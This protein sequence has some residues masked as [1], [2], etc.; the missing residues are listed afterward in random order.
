MQLRTIIFGNR[1]G[2]L[3]RFFIPVTAQNRKIDIEPGQHPM[4][5]LIHCPITQQAY[6]PTPDWNRGGEIIAP[7]PVPIDH[8][9]VM[10]DHFTGQRQ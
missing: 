4:H 2:H 5:I 1:G 3:S 8:P 10:R 7:P 9:V 6:L